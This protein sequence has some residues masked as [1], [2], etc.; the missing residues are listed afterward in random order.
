MRAP[1]KHAQRGACGGNGGDERAALLRRRAPCRVQMAH[2]ALPS[3]MEKGSPL[4]RA[5][6]PEGEPASAPVSA[7]RQGHGQGGEA[8]AGT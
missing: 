8:A 5:L 6:R 7:R 1:V 3:L 4:S 2:K